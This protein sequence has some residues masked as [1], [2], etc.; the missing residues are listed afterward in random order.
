MRCKPKIKKK[1]RRN[2][3]KERQIFE[4]MQCILNLYKW[5]LELF[6]IKDDVNFQTSNKVFQ[7]LKNQTIM[8]MLDTGFLGFGYR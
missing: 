3:K 6:K 4:Y 7:S 5:L 2:E 8:H 1:K